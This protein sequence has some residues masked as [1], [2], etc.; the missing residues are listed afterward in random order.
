MITMKDVIREGNPLLHEKA[1]DV[2]FP[3]SDED[4]DLALDMMEYVY[5]SI[6]EELQKQYD[7]K[8][9]VG[10]ACPQLG[11]LKKIIAISAPDE[12]GVEHDFL[13]INPKIISYSDELTYLE[14][15]E[16]CLSVDRYCPGLVH[17][18]KRVTFE[19]Y[20]VDCETGK[21]EKKQMRLKGYLAVVFQHEYDHLQGILYVDRI[22]KE[23]PMFVPSN[24]SPVKFKQFSLEENNEKTN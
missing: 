17:R 7:L 19:S 20:F 2:V 23:N 10:L 8:P 21:I 13:L 16:G 18:S 11:I 4:Y 9:A 15:G 24:S 12:E 1:V 5:N 6:D 22:N 14:G 3:I